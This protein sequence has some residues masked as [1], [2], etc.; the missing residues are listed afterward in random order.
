MLMNI[1]DTNYHAF[2]E[3]GKNMVKIIVYALFSKLCAFFC[4]YI[5]LIYNVYIAG[6]E[7]NDSKALQ[8]SG[9]SVMSETS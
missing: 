9:S 1:G 6:L 2:K 3:Q 7:F 4:Q 8:H 5:L